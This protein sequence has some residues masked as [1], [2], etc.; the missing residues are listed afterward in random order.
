MSLSCQIQ[1]YWLERNCGL[2]RRLLTSFVEERGLVEIAHER[3]VVEVDPDKELLVVLLLQ[4]GVELDQTLIRGCCSFLVGLVVHDV[5]EV[6]EHPLDP[7]IM[8]FGEFKL[9]GQKR[10]KPSV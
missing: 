6:L 9:V 4:E 5:I 10:S 3:W 8:K 1:I 2:F 7:Y